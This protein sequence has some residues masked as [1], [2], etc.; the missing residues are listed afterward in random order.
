MGGH[1]KG[2]ARGGTVDIWG[3]YFTHLEIRAESQVLRGSKSR[4]GSRRVR[5]SNGQVGMGAIG[6][7]VLHP[8]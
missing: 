5:E 2:G 7:W 6:P 3:W 4:G 1:G 8:P